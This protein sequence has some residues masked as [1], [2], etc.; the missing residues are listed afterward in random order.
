MIPLRSGITIKLLDYFFLNPQES[1]Y[2][3][4]LSRKLDM[5]KRNLVKKIRQLESEG[6]LKSQAR[7]N[8]KLYSVNKAY[9]L[10]EELRKIFLK[11]IGLESRLKKAAKSVK[12]IREAYIYGSYAGNKMEAHSDID[13]LVIGVHN[14]AQLQKGI[15]LLQKETGREINTV[16]MD[17][18]EY[19]KRIKNKDP[20]IR[21]ILNKKHVRII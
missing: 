13:L 21:G 18:N 3:N 4:E 19:C 6:I 20:F 2:V 14:I 8:L 17:E 7:G 12:G 5:D 9:P 1:L 15:N 10:Y 16:N 11:T